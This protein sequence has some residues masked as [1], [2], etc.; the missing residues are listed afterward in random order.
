MGEDQHGG[1]RVTGS[2]VDQITV[3]QINV[4]RFDVANAAFWLA[5]VASWLADPD[6]AHWFA[7]DLWAGAG[8]DAGPPLTV[9]VGRAAAALRATLDADRTAR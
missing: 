2:R 5:Q 1:G 9:I 7:E 3:D 8:Q 6:H 4:D